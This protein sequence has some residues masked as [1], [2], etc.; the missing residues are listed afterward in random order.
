MRI[1]LKD[2]S[3]EVELN[4]I[5]GDFDRHGNPRLYFRRKGF[6]KVRL[7]EPVGTPAFLEEHRAALAATQ[8]KIPALPPVRKPPA[9]NSLAWLIEQYKASAEYKA[10]DPATITARNRDLDGLVKHHG[11]KRFA[12]L[13]RKHLKAL[14]DAKAETPHAANNWVK[15]VRGLFR[16]AID[17][18]HV[19]DNP[20]ADVRKIRTASDG[21]HTWTIAEILQYMAKWPANSKEGLAL[22]L[23]FYFGVRRSDVVKL[24]RQMETAP[25]ALRLVEYKGR[26]R[27]VKVTDLTIQPE[28]RAVLDQ[29]AGD[30]NHLT[31]LVTAYGASFTA[32]GFGNWFKKRCVL[33]GLDHCSAHGLRKAGATIAADNGATDYDLMGMYG[34]A[35]PAQAHP[36][37]KRAN[38]KRLAARASRLV[39]L[40]QK[41]NE[42]VPP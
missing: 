35:N 27:K 15:T 7:R 20:A 39:T 5:I 28:L 40:D 29:R 14:R 12:K 34:W 2:G 38:R 30:H 21:H 8:S 32:N 13:R 25:D 16:W 24:G 11:T 6:K 19:A 22:A 4:Y 9:K 17:A 1:I 41:K 18:E 10:L 37:T 36:Y 42:G 33:A 3:G 26:R 31:Y 23:L